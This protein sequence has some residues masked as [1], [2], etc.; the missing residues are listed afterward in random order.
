[1]KHPSVALLCVGMLGCAAALPAGQLANSAQDAPSNPTPLEYN[2]MLTS[3]ATVD[4]V[5]AA[6]AAT[7]LPACTA[8]ETAAAPPAG[9]GGTANPF[10]GGFGFPGFGMSGGFPGF[11]GFPGFGASLASQNPSPFTFGPAA[12]PTG[13]TGL[14]GGSGLRWVPRLRAQSSETPGFPGF[15]GGFGFGFPGLGGM[16]GGGGTPSSSGFAG[17]PGFMAFPGMLGGFGAPQAQPQAQAASVPASGGHGT[18][19]A[20]NQSNPGPSL[21]NHQARQVGGNN[22][23]GMIP[24]GFNYVFGTPPVIPF[25][26]GSGGMFA[27]GNGFNGD[28][29]GAGFLGGG[30]LPP[31]SLTSATAS[32]APT[33]DSTPATATPAASTSTTAG[34]P[35]AS[36][37]SSS[38]SPP[39]ASTAT[40]ASSTATPPGAS[41][42]SSASSA[43]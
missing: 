3:N 33:A 1:M 43:E 16:F 14:G 19:E 8:P 25:N 5:P 40:S 41:S 15:G 13:S 29:F 17:F 10:M 22:E 23:Q 7:P 2:I 6:A 36:D 28:A 18:N 20:L 31:L 21:H 27:P 26:T 11:P 35:A 38:T 12:G 34:S 9:S 30:E 32:V 42:T 4:P 24:P 39:S 37:I